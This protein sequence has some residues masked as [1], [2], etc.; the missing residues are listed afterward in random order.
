MEGF[1]HPLRITILSL[2]LMN[3]VLNA[4]AEPVTTI[5]NN[6]DP[7]NRV[8][9]VVLGDGYTTAEL[10]QFASDVETA[11]NG[12]FGQ[13]PFREYRRYFNVH[14]VDVVSAESGV[15]HPEDGTYKNTALDAY[16]NCG[17]TE[18]AICA[19][20]SKVDAIL[21]TSVDADQRDIIL[22]IVNDSAYGGTGGTMS[23]VSTHT[24]TV[25]LVLHEVGHSFGLLADEYDY[26]NCSTTSYEPSQVN[27]TID[28]DPE[29]IKW[30]QGGGPP[31]GWI[32][33]GTAIPTTDTV[34][35]QPGLYEGAKYCAFDVY[36]PT[37]NS[38]M[39]ALNRPFD[40]INTEQLIKR[41]YNWVSP[42]DSTSPAQDTV[43]LQ[44]TQ[45][46][47][48]RASVMRPRTHSLEVEWFVN[49][50]YQSSGSEFTF[51]TAS[52]AQGIY[53][54]TADVTDPTSLVRYDPANVLLDSHSWTVSVT[55]DCITDS[56][57][58]GTPDCN[59]DCPDDPQ[60][61]SP[62]TCGCGTPDDDSDD[63]GALNCEDACPA[64]PYKIMTGICGCGIADDD[65]D[66]DGTP[67]CND[68]CPD[69]PYKTVPEVCGCGIPDTDTDDDGTP[70]CND[71]CPDDP[72]KIQPGQ[73]GCGNSE[74]DSDNDGTADC[75]DEDDDNDGVTEIEEQ[76]PDGDNP[77]Y[78]GN[79][80]ALPDSRQNNVA[81]LHTHD[82]QS[83]VTL[84][85]ASGATLSN[86]MAQPNPSAGDAPEDAEFAL[87]FFEFQIHNFSGTATKLTLYLPDGANPADTYYKYGP[88][89]DD[90]SD[91]WYEF[92][93]DGQTGAEISGNVIHLHFVDGLRGDDDLTP[94]GIIADI[95]GPAAN[96][97]PT[98]DTPNPDPP[99]SGSGGGGGGGCFIQS[100]Q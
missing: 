83:Y 16:Y 23:V 93:Y 40:Q 97:N 39:R 51:D 61:T 67:D 85:V 69:D 78:D 4:W 47:E 74:L 80:D 18:R 12:F 48:F 56:D 32:E 15:D 37:Y 38:K 49:N 29:H 11:V 9:L 62:G 100:L 71:E 20:Y 45:A 99:A 50:Q 24:Q 36:R 5:R 34:T 98:A 54:V 88:T 6:G 13:E 96:V 30:N 82:G 42:L 21:S 14:R 95:G 25:E 17:G 7:A 73:C 57:D 66:D 52:F 91:H 2:F 89:P 68:D 70:D 64:D 27:V 58:D 79:D 55:P 46:Q 35:G 84:A 33:S 86:C 90:P 63:D 75:L 22:V 26:G 81:S 8:D 53:T 43:V 65:S 31:T 44:K 10:T 3:A 72:V 92:L 1:V 76:G 41:I 19:S 59:D 60:K 94:N 28:T 87:G 77:D